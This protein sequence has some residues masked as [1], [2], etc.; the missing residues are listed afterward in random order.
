VG[1]DVQT[2]R[3][4]ENDQRTLVVAERL[5]VVAAVLL[6]KSQVD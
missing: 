5:L 3:C 4:Q 6:P 1:A 2:L